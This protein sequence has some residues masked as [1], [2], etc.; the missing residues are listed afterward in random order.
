MPP[1][2]RSWLD[3]LEYVRLDSAMLRALAH[4]TRS[5][6]LSS[7]RLDGPATSAM[8]AQRLDTNSGQTSYHARI[9]ADVGLVLEDEDRGTGRERWWRAAHKGHSWSELDFE[10][11][12][13]DR[14]AAEWLQRSYHRMYVNW[15]GQWFDERREWSDE[16]RE[17]A[18]LGDAAFMATPELATE[19]VRAH[20]ALVE[21]FAARGEDLDP[22]DPDVERYTV[23]TQSF[24]G[25]DMR[26]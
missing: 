16:W 17:A 1:D 9:L 10:E 6:I 11:D 23:L 15:V 4:P 21:E 3:G 7:L 19:F 22:D 14:H 18:N 12:P 8:L 5:R 24:P 2:P 13:E 26:P 25:R 20:H